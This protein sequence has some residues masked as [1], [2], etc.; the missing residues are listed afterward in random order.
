M[1][2][3]LYQIKPVSHRESA[4][5][6]LR[7]DRHRHQHREAE[8]GVLSEPILECEVRSRER[9]SVLD[10]LSG[11]LRLRALDLAPQLLGGFG[12]PGCLG[13]LR[14]QLPDARIS[15]LDGLLVGIVGGCALQ[16][17]LLRLDLR[18]CFP[19][20]LTFTLRLFL[21]LERLRAIS[22]TIHG[23][24][25]PLRPAIRRP[26]GF[27]RRGYEGVTYIAAAIKIDE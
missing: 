4:V 17:L 11:R 27:C 25:L 9:E 7:E 24:V 10:A 26:A 2:P 23:F 19:L 15:L 18:V 5:L 12:A 3:D 21:L 14:L 13:H 6:R 1:I 16:Q 8:C 20:P 22:L